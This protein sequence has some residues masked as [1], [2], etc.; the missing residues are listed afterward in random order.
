MKDKI[1]GTFH[2]DVATKQLYLHTDDKGWYSRDTLVL[3][4]VFVAN[5][6]AKC[7]MLKDGQE[8]QA[9]SRLCLV[10]D[11]KQDG[12]LVRAYDDAPDAFVIETD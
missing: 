5:D 12:L 8:T 11:K 7:V 2:Y 1:T 6:K 4:P 3:R 10:F 9:L